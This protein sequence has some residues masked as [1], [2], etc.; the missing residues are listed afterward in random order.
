MKRHFTLFTVLFLFIISGCSNKT[1]EKL[2]GTQAYQTNGS[3]TGVTSTVTGAD[4]TEVGTVT[5]TALADNGNSAIGNLANAAKSVFYAADICL[6]AL[7]SPAGGP[8]DDGWYDFSPHYASFASSVKMKFYMADKVTQVPP[9]LA[10]EYIK[11][12]MTGTGT[13]YTAEYFITLDNTAAGRLNSISGTL[14][15]YDHNLFIQYT[16]TV[17]G[18]D[19]STPAFEMA[20]NGPVVRSVAM[21]AS[22]ATAKF[23]KSGS[24][25][26]CDLFMAASWSWTCSG[27]ASF[28]AARGHYFGTCVDMPQSRSYDISI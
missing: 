6:T 2:L 10:H 22:A 8:D 26:Q 25:Y 23:S 20:A 27:T 16:H 19:L 12:R 3:G 13:D 11:V 28:D 4:G 7:P 17:T 15:Y 1:K 9:S 24:K 5:A 21:N 18:G 14:S